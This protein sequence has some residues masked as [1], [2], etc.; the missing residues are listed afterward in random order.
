MVARNNCKAMRKILFLGVVVLLTACATRKTSTT[1]VDYYNQMKSL[2]QLVSR[3]ERLTQVYKD[4]MMF[5]RG[6]SERSSNMADSASH[7]ETSYAMSDARI[8]HGKLHHS[9]QNKD[10]VPARVITKIREVEKRD[11]LYISKSDTVYVEKDRKQV[12]EKRR[13]G[14]SFFYTSGV[15]AWILLLSAG[16]W[17]LYK[18]KKGEK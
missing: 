11:T 12:V 4:S 8:T 17:F 10:S 18:V 6:L 2:E 13:P 16:I 9:I 3:Y 5:M 15:T 1:Q 7:L 14:D